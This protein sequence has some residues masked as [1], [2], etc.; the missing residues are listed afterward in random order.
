M[1][2]VTY[3]ATL[4][5]LERANKALRESDFG[6]KANLAFSTLLACS[7]VTK[8]F[9]GQPIQYD[10]FKRICEALKLNWREIATFS[11]DESLEPIGI[12]GGGIM[13]TSEEVEPVQTLRRV[14]VIDEE[15]QKVI[16]AI[17]LEGDIYSV[18]NIEVFNLI[19]QK[20]SGKTIKIIDWQP[21]SIRLIVEGSQKD[22]NQL[23]SRIQSGELKELSGFPVKDIQVLDESSDDKWDLVR[24]I[25]NQAV[26]GRNLSDADLSDADLSGANL[27]KANLIRADLSGADLSEANLRGANLIK[28]DLRGAN[29]Q[30]ATFGDNLGISESHKD[31]L[32]DR[33]A[34]FEDAPGDRSPIHI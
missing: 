1:T 23:V 9:G 19:L 31:K 6:S 21:G 4:E 14:T 12:S 7:T 34:I 2:Y 18:Q 17:I 28:A 24:E 29:V 8:F 15:S 5:G 16:L 30:Y 32:K 11:K 26:A 25:T 20:H 33:G 22:I 27:N 13:E 3:V 10:T